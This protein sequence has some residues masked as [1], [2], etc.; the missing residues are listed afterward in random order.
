VLLA[1]T[2]LFVMLLAAC[3]QS[4]PAPPPGT[5]AGTY[6]ISV[7]GRAPDGTVVTTGLTLIVT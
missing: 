3:G 6:V 1:A 4:T 7:E 2:L 5:P